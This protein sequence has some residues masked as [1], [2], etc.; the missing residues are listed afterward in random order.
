MLGK[1]GDALLGKKEVEVLE[2]CLNHEQ[3][4]KSR[5]KGTV[6]IG[7]SS[8]S[9]EDTEHIHTVDL[10]NNQMQHEDDF[11]LCTAIRWDLECT[12]RKR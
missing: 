6:P 5:Q 4:R 9:P 12:D 3:Q 1:S 7:T 8:S 10:Q 2:G 11:F